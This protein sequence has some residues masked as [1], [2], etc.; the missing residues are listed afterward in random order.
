MALDGE[1]VLER[2]LLIAARRHV[3]IHHLTVQQIQEKVSI[4]FDIELDRQMQH[5][6]AH[7]IAS[8]LELAI[9]NELG[10]D[11][12]V[13]THIEPMEPSEIQGYEAPASTTAQIASGLAQRALEVTAISNVHNIRVRATTA[14][15]VVNYHCR[16]DPALSVG[17]VHDHVDELER[18]MQEDFP[19]IVRIVGHAEPV[20]A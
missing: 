6:Q 3:R 20:S 10:S 9:A 16:V 12:E 13:E 7:E 2:V 14:G 5:G 11:V 17:T 19:A 18:K 4:S 15:L 1:T 8:S